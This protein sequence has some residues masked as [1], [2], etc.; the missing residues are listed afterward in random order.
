MGWWKSYEFRWVSMNSE[1]FVKYEL[2]YILGGDDNSNELEWKP[3]TS[4]NIY[5]WSTISLGGDVM[6]RYNKFPWISMNYFLMNAQ[7]MSMSFTEM[8][9]LWWVMS[10]AISMNNFMERY[11]VWEWW[12]IQW[13]S[14]NSDEVHFL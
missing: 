5:V 12:P 14:T 13:I 4:C 1:L 9:S 7:C 3:T 10:T 6:N 11:N 8:L 2:L